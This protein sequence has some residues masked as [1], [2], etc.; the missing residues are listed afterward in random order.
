MSSA[1][2]YSLG[3]LQIVDCIDHIVTGRGLGRVTAIALFVMD[4]ATL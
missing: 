3:A 1:L 2:L 4:E